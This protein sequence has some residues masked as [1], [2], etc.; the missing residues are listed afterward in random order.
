VPEDRKQKKRQQHALAG[1]H[2]LAV[3]LWAFALALPL[4]FAAQTVLSRLPGVT[5]SLVMLLL[6]IGLGVVF[7]VIGV[8]V[9]A[10]TEAPL[11]ARAAAGVFGARRAAAL[12]RNA[13][14]VASFCNDVIG[15]VTGTLS[16]ALAIAIVMRVVT[17]VSAAAG[18]AAGVVVSSLVASLIVAGKA[19]GK[20]F[21]LRHSTAIVFEAGR[22]LEGVE[23]LRAAVRWKGRGGRARDAAA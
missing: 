20:V 8:A 9:T 4:G 5:L 22:F 12:V 1:R 7:D 2:A 18:L 6:V 3:G 13:H 10:A 16:G 14:E 19:Y 15:D 17:G 23:A 21:A 11:H